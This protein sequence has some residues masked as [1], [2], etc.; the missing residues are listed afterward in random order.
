MNPADILDLVDASWAVS[1]ALAEDLGTSGDLTTRALVPAGR[2]ARGA[3]LA[4]A[5]GVIVGHAT[6]VL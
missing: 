1:R 2:G 4:R 6:T 3:F 5:D